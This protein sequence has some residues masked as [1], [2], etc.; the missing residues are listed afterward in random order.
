MIYIIQADCYYKIGISDD[1]EKRLLQV[2][3]GCPIPPTILA[4][5]KTKSRKQDEMLEYKAHKKFSKKRTNGEWFL[6]SE[7]EL[8]EAISFF[9]EYLNSSLRIQPILQDKCVNPNLFTRDEA[10]AFLTKNISN[11]L[12]LSWL[13]SKGL[14]PRSN[15]SWIANSN[16]ELQKHFQI[17]IK[18]INKEKGRIKLMNEAKR[19]KKEKEIAQIKKKWT[20]KLT[21]R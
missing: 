9:S 14:N 15:Q 20:P 12:H 2:S 13:I 17:N 11:Q 21:S 16:Y 19:K 18:E 6:L 3:T 7:D 5:F 8:K 1:P 4:T 10:L